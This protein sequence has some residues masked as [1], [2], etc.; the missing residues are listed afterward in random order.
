VLMLVILETI[1]T[2]FDFSVLF[3]PLIIRNGQKMAIQV[4]PKMLSYDSQVSQG[5]ISTAVQI[6]FAWRIHLISQSNL[7]LG[8][9]SVLSFLSLTGAI[10]TTTCVSLIPEYSRFH[11]FAYGSRTGLAWTDS[12]ITRI[13]IRRATAF[14]ISSSPMTEILVTVETGVITSFSTILDVALFLNVIG[15]FCLSKIYTNSLLSALNARSSWNEL[16][17][18][19]RR[20]VDISFCDVGEK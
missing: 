2:G 18:S 16:F 14:N 9:I 8:F 7:A 19:R 11:E 6:F 17:D 10:T 4:A 13:I 20:N 1:N 15:D 3:E 12:L 5:V